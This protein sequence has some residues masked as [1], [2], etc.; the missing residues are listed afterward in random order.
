MRKS[1]YVFDVTKWFQKKIGRF[2]EILWSS[3]NVR[4]F[5]C[6]Y[7]FTRNFYNFCAILGLLISKPILNTQW[8]GNQKANL[9]GLST[10]C[11]GVLYSSQRIGAPYCSNEKKG[12]RQK[13]RPFYR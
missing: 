12:D 1:P 8:N 6:A 4:T 10:N 3:Q 9:D 5:L 13:P 2:F 7:T 11:L